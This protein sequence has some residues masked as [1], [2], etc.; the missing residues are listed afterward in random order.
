MPHMATWESNGVG[1]KEQRSEDRTWA[2]AFLMV[3]IRKTRQDRVNH[4]GW[5][6]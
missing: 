6:S 5:V 3:S 1:Q 4:L 2:Q